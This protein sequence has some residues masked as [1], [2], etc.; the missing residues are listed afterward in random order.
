MFS[1]F[2]RSLVRTNFNNSKACFSS[3]NLKRSLLEVF[4]RQDLSDPHYQAAVFNPLFP[5]ENHKVQYRQDASANYEVTKLKNGITVVTESQ[6]FPNVV[7]MGILL[8][9]GTR[10]ETHETSGALHSI[11]QTYYKTVLNTNETINYG[12][13]QMSGGQFEMDYDHENAYFK[14]NCLQHDVV[15]IFNMMADCALEP[16]SVVA[17]NAAMD[18]MHFQH[19]LEAYLKT[20]HLIND[21]LFQTAY[22]NHGLGLPLHGLTH[23]YKYLHAHVLQKFQLEN[24]NPNR[25]FV[26]AAGIE[27]HQE[28]VELVESK[29][30]FIPAATGNTAQRQPAEYTGGENRNQTDENNITL[31]LA[32]RSV[33]WTSS[34]IFALQV[35]STLL[36]TSNAWTGNSRLHNRSASNIL[37][38]HSFVDAVNTLNFNFSDTG[39]FGL[40]VTGSAS[41]AHQLLEVTTSELKGLTTI[42]KEELQR[43]KNAT[44]SNILT[45]LQRQTDRLEE[46]VKNVKAYG[47]VV[48]HSYADQIESV[49][50]DQIANV[51][52]KI[53][54]SRP[55][56]I[57]EGGEVATLP[58]LDRI[59]NLVKP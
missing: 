9:V 49:T 2:S 48:H 5:L 46:T 25:I 56:F 17:A 23:N 40:S 36:G 12:M 11:K 19:E 47:K 27:N 59:E 39:L 7:D 41:N 6:V 55:T 43:A 4:N 32:F 8:D 57:A 10:D 35:V 53:I 22:G 45:A 28:F 13:V 52:G 54:S 21:T 31:A 42:S 20:G 30:S 29:L 33:P 15:D 18:K 37:N 1:K 50:A 24:I 34:D 14:A 44:K 26:S 16:R 51:V 3:L 38:K 58:S